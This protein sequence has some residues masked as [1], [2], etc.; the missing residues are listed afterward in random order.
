MGTEIKDGS[1]STLKS[2]GAE[3]SPFLHFFVVGGLSWTLH[4]SGVTFISIPSL[5][6]WADLGKSLNLSEP[7]TLFFNLSKD[8]NMHLQHCPKH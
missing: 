6:S 3:E 8:N 5:L 7:P 4:E 2:S 1:T